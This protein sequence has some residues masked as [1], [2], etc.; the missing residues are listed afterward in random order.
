M[1]KE[2]VFKKI[3]KESELV[4]SLNPDLLPF[5][6]PKKLLDFWRAKF[7]DYI[8]HSKGIG[9]GTINAFYDCLYCREEKNYHIIL[10]FCYQ[11]IGAQGKVITR[12]YCQ[13]I[14]SKIDAD[15][16]ETSKKV[17][18]S[19]SQNDYCVGDVNLNEFILESMYSWMFPTLGIPGPQTHR[20]GNGEIV[21]SDIIHIKGLYKMLDSKPEK[22][23]LYSCQKGFSR[24]DEGLIFPEVYYRV[25]NIIQDNID[26]FYAKLS[27]RSEKF[28]KFKEDY[29]TLIARGKLK[30]NL[31][32]EELS[33]FFSHKFGIIPPE[34]WSSE[35][36]EKYQPQEIQIESRWKLDKIVDEHFKNNPK[37]FKNNLEPLLRTKINSSTDLFS[38][39]S[40]L[41][42]INSIDFV[43]DE[44][45]EV[46]DLI[47]K[48]QDLLPISENVDVYNLLYGIM[49]KLT[50]LSEKTDD[51]K[52]GKASMQLAKRIES[53]IETIYFPEEIITG[54][55]NKLKL[56]ELKFKELKKIISVSKRWA[57]IAKRTRSGV[58]C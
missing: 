5:L 42:K 48:N 53:L 12:E 10:R 45:M 2:N 3:E 56:N 40:A 33:T 34:R 50:L 8:M 55:F 32:T 22:T 54:I 29:Y 15:A 51:T 44:I 1:P 35:L 38:F 13:K 4:Y 57:T 9:G 28:K 14:L 20:L 19:P 49:E 16:I 58:G 52:V 43:G 25:E 18:V 47:D 36:A 41:K 17:T 24:N 37:Q 27:K 39:I 26:R 7:C 31:N 11:Y 23:I 30:S 6:F 21:V 46:E